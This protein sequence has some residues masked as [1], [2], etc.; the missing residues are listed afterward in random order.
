MQFQS[1]ILRVFK[2]LR[3][4]GSEMTC[5]LNRNKKSQVTCLARTQHKEKNGQMKGTSSFNYTAFIATGLLHRKFQKLCLGFRNELLLVLRLR[6]E[7]VGSGKL[8]II[9]FER[10][11]ITCVVCPEETLEGIPTCFIN[12]E[13]YSQPLRREDKEQSRQ[14]ENFPIWYY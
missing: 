1:S 2:V 3:C 11:P 4:C 7:A 8:F 6:L 12:Q 14:T 13:S 9:Q 5:L 10:K